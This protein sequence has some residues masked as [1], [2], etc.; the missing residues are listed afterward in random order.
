[1]NFD[2][3][4]SPGPPTDRVELLSRESKQRQVCRENG[5]LWVKSPEL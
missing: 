4:G 5:R 1:M 3:I 2:G